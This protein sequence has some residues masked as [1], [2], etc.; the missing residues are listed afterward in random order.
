M[1]TRLSLVLALCLSASFS[2]VA[3]A[4]EAA[5]SSAPSALLKRLP[6]KAISLRWQQVSSRPPVWAHLWCVP[7]GHSKEREMMMGEKKSGPVTRADI[8]GGPSIESSPFTLELY[9]VEEENPVGWKKLSGVNFTQGKDV[10]EIHTRFLDAGTRR[11]PVLLLHFGFTHWHE[12]EVFTLARGWSGPIAHQTFGW[13]GEGES[14]VFQKFSRT[15]K[16]RMVI[17]EEVRSESGSERGVFRWNGREWIDASQKWLVIGASSPSRKIIDSLVARKGY[18]EVKRSNEFKGL[19]PGY[20]I[21]LVGRYRSP[22]EAREQARDLQK[23]GEKPSVR[24]A[25]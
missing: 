6:A 12:W 11:S 17:D 16:G 8:N 21:W 1:K 15:E 14:H 19:R 20:W 9:E 7:R 18:G 25:G 23:I 22:K 4:Q 2:I 24:N 10:Q 3:R 13:G 5:A